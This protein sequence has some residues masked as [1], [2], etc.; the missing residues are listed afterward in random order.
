MVVSFGV[1]SLALGLLRGSA[2]VCCCLDD[3]SSHVKSQQLL[4]CEGFQ[5]SCRFD[6]PQRTAW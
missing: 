1:H 3:L 4:Y 6:F 2:A 5:V